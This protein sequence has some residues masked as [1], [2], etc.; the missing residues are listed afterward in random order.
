MILILLGPPGIGKGTQAS[1]LSDILKINHIATGDIFRKNFKENTELGILIKKIIAQGLL[2]PDDITNQMIA[3]YLSKD[4][5]TK[6]FLLDG[7]PRNVLQAR[8]LDDF[9]KNSHLF[10]TKVIYFNAGTQDLMKRIVGR[11]ICPEC[12]K[13]YHIENIP[14]KTPGICDK[15]QKTLIQRE[16]DKP[17]TFL[18][19]LKV[20]NQETLPLVQ[21][22]REQNQLFEVDGMQNI[23]QVTKMILEVL[24]TDRK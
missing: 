18:K 2:V 22:Y 24:E 21:Y 3:D 6:D 15:D 20:F 8:F 13:V 19:R 10:L 14:P 1:V 5:A 9:F 23:D 12:G 17:E 4:I 11:R 7:F 16:D